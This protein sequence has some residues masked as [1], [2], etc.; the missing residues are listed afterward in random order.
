MENN[1]QKQGHG[2]SARKREEAA[3]H[4]STLEIAD[5]IL[6][7]GRC[8]KC[9]AGTLFMYM[10]SNPE[11][12]FNYYCSN[13]DCDHRGDYREITK[14]DRLMFSMAQITGTLVNTYGEDTI[15]NSINNYKSKPAEPTKSEEKIA[16]PAE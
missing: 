14:G 9:D 12:I 4:N 3:I 13:P 7:I 5:N 11:N 2:N 16:Q 15:V 10:K 1:N 6:P 8:G